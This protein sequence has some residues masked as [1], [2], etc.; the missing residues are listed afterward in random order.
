MAELNYVPFGEVVLRLLAAGGLAFIIGLER[1]IKK[2]SFGLRTHMLLSIGTAAF[3]LLL[4]ELTMDMNRTSGAIN[5]D[6]A[7]VI[8]GIIA[9]ISFLGAGSIIRSDDEIKGATTGAG[10]WML[11]GIGLA[12]GLG[13]YLHAALITGLILVIVVALHPLD[14]WLAANMA[15]KDDDG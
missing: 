9:G 6:P 11:G 2:K 8:E 14:R 7:R 15:K 3:V 13:L 10:I 1:E 5:I 4:M 12:C